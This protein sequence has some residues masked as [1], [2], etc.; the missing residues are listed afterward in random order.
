MFNISFADNEET[1]RKQNKSGFVGG[2]YGVFNDWFSS[3]LN[4]F[5]SSSSCLVC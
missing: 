5:S 4:Y 3:E 1:E 2:T